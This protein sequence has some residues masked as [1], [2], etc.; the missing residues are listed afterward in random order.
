MAKSTNVMRDI[1]DSN[2]NIISDTLKDND[3]KGRTPFLRAEANM[4]NFLNDKL[5]IKTNVS[6]KFMSEAERYIE[7]SVSDETDYSE[8]PEARKQWP[9]FA[10]EIYV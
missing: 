5:A 10:V 9:G 7:I 2:A 4:E 1:F 3:L 6:I 8:L